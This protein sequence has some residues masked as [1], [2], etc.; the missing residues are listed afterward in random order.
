MRLDTLANAIELQSKYVEPMSMFDPEPETPEQRRVWKEGFHRAIYRSFIGAA[1]LASVYMEPISDAQVGPTLDHLNARQC[2]A[3]C[4]QRFAAYNPWLHPQQDHD[5]FGGFGDWLFQ[6][7]LSDATSRT[8]MEESFRLNQGRAHGCQER[9]QLE[10]DHPSDELRQ[11]RR[12]CPIQAEGLSHADAHLLALELLRLLWACGRMAEQ[13]PFDGLAPPRA[14]DGTYGPIF[15]WDAFAPSLVFCE[16]LPSSTGEGSSPPC[17]LYLKEPD[18][19]EQPGD[20]ESA[21]YP[22]VLLEIADGTDERRNRLFFEESIF[23]PPTRYKFFVYFLHRHLRA[24]FENNFFEPDTGHAMEN[25][26]GTFLSSLRIFAR[27]DGEEAEPYYPDALG[28]LLW[29]QFLDGADVLL[30]WGPPQDR[31]LMED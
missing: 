20:E 5:V 22:Q 31:I 6:D 10:P 30:P 12:G 2:A 23:L 26:F 14:M 21:M 25:D 16:E 1:S 7:I 29:A 4:A 18:D 17:R 9:C 8:A 13:I 27:D 24:A 15:L 3:V 28:H 11:A 19:E